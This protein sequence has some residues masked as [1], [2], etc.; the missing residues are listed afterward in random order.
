MKKTMGEK[1]NDLRKLRK[2]TQDELAEKM[3]VSSQA[4]S[5]W[6]KDISIPDLPVLVELSEFFNI[7]LDELVKERDETV[8]YVPMEARKNINEMFLRVNILSVDGDKVKVNLPLVFVKMAADMKIELPEFNG[9]EILKGLDLHMI[10]SLIEN[11]A[12]GKIVEIE[13]SQGDIVEVMVE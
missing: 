5:K 6:E 4:V 12:I 13:S 7:S 9:S 2:M 11:G 8:R 10:I 3:G 1:I